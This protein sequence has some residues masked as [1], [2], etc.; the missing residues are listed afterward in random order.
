MARWF[1]LNSTTRHHLNQRAA[2]TIPWTASQLSRKI[3]SWW[4]VAVSKTQAWWTVGLLTRMEWCR[5]RTRATRVSKTPVSSK[6]WGLAE[7]WW[8]SRATALKW[9]RIQP[10]R[11]KSNSSADLET[12]QPALGVS[13]VSAKYRVQDQ[14]V[15]KESTVLTESETFRAPR[16]WTG[17][18][19]TWWCR[20]RSLARRTSET[21]LIRDSRTLRLSTNSSLA[22]SKPEDQFVQRL[23]R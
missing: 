10:D 22:F 23:L 17:L 9:A 21:L 15:F 6:S 4:T 13:E 3:T 7:A 14:Q 11:D 8:D 1:K 5:A 18:L 16:A 2:K 12:S 20:S 19:T